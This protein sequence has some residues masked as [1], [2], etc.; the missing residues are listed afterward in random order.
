LQD[1]QQL[2]ELAIAE[3]CLKLR[4]DAGR[5]DEGEEVQQLVEKLKVLEARAKADSKGVWTESAQPL[6]TAYE[7]SNPQDFVSKHKGKSLEGE[8]NAWPIKSV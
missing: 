6:Q 4:D 1:G 3:G 2:P 7:L 8:M 5:R